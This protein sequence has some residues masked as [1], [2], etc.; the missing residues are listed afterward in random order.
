MTLLWVPLSL[1]E[2]LE[3]LRRCSRTLTYLE[4]RLDQKAD[5]ED[6]WLSLW[7]QIASM[8]RLRHLK[9]ERPQAWFHVDYLHYNSSAKSDFVD[10]DEISKGLARL[11]E[12]ERSWE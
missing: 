4:L 7:E 8:E 1:V 3:I 12:A 9:L 11:V 10:R 2:L 6:A 5:R